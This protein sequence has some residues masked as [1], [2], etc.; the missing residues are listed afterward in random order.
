MARVT[1]NSAGLAAVLA[2]ARDYRDQL[3]EEIADDSRRYVPILSGD[4]R[5]SIR[6]DLGG[7]EVA[8][9]WYGDVAA[10]VDYHLYQ[11]FGT[12]RMDAQPYIRPAVYQ[13][14]G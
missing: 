10:D 12:S 11:E 9:I 6:T 3:T 8:V 5:A 14:R 1:I 2:A 4:L 13:Y 7:P